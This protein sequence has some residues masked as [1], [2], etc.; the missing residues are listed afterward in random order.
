M[1]D[2]NIALE[3]DCMPLGKIRIADD[4]IA[5]I[6]GTAAAEVDGVITGAYPLYQG[7]MSPRFTKRN[8]ARGV[9]ISFEDE[10]VKVSIS[11][12]MKYGYKIHQISE[13]I[14]KRVAI[15]LETMAGVRVDEVNVSVVGLR[16]EKVK[17]ATERK[18][19][20]KAMARYRAV[21]RRRYY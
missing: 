14:Q 19:T 9:K 4:V 1:N 8:F 20:Q 12:V 21:Q 16:V 17:Q 6:A 7:E 10:V 3:K 11:V 18:S 2:T 13:E 15:A 5:V